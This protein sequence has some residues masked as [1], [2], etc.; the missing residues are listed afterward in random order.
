MNGCLSWRLRRE[1]S[2]QRRNDV[3]GDVR[4]G[5][6]GGRGGGGRGG[7]GS[8]KKRPYVPLSPLFFRSSSWASFFR[9]AL[10]SFRPLGSHRRRPPPP[11]P[12]LQNH[13]PHPRRDRDALRGWRRT[14][15]RG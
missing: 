10:L 4:N 5:S 11:T 3:N 6:A 13:P 14:T 15:G 2:S 9:C 8:C 12:P 1:R 7:G